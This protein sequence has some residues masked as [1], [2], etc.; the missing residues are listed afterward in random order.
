[1]VFFAG[2]FL[3]NTLLMLEASAQIDSESLEKTWVSSPKT[4]EQ[5]ICLRNH[6]PIESPYVIRDV[7]RRQRLG[8]EGYLS[9]SSARLIN[10]SRKVSID[11]HCPG[12]SWTLNRTQIE[13]PSADFHSYQWA[14]A[15]SGESIRVERDD[16]RDEWVPADARARIGFPS[17]P[18]ERGTPV[19]VAILDSG[20]AADHQEFQG[21]VERGAAFAYRDSDGHGTHV[22]GIIAAARDGR[23]ID[24]VYP[25]SRLMP[26]AV[27]E[28]NAGEGALFSML[29]RIAEGIVISVDQGA[30]IIN[31][32]LGWPDSVN[33]EVLRQ[34]VLYAEN[35]GVIIVAAAGN[36]ST[37]AS[38]YPCR[39][40]GVICVA[41]M[42]PDGGFAAFSNFGHGVDLVA[43]GYR[44]LSTIPLRNAPISF[45][46]GRGYD[47][48]SG[49]SM[50]APHVTGIL[51]KALDAGILPNELRA[52]IAAL[53]GPLW[54]EAQEGGFALAGEPIRSVQWGALLEASMDYQQ[55]LAKVRGNHIL[56]SLRTKEE[57]DVVLS[58]CQLKQSLGG[59]EVEWA[60]KN[61]S[62]TGIHIPDVL[63]QLEGQL[64]TEQGAVID[65]ALV[66]GEWGVRL[67]FSLGDEQVWPV[68]AERT[69]KVLV[70]APCAALRA[71]SRWVI[72]WGFSSKIN[73]FSSI[74]EFR[75][76]REW[77]TETSELLETQV[78]IE[79]CSVSCKI[80]W[81]VPVDRNHESIRS[82]RGLDEVNAR[83][84]AY[85]RIDNSRKR[86][87]LAWVNLADRV[88]NKHRVF[89]TGLEIS[90]DIQSSQIL[91]AWILPR[92]NQRPEVALLMKDSGQNQNSGFR[93]GFYEL[94]GSRSRMDDWMIAQSTLIVHPQMFWWRPSEF[95]SCRPAWVIPGPVPV[96]DQPSYDPWNPEPAQD[97]RG[98]LYTRV[99]DQWRALPLDRDQQILSAVPPTLRCGVG[100]IR[101]LQSKGSDYRISIQEFDVTLQETNTRN[102]WE[103]GNFRLAQQTHFRNLIGL[104]TIYGPG[105]AGFTGPTNDQTLRV[106]VRN[107]D[108]QW[109][110]RTLPQARFSDSWQQAIGV[111]P[112]KQGT[113]VQSLYDLAWVG[114]PLDTSIESHSSTISPQHRL[115]LERF[116]FLP[117]ALF[118]RSFFPLLDASGQM[119][120][121]RLSEVASREALDCVVWDAL[122]QRLR[123]PTE[124]RWV[125]PVEGDRLSV[126]A[127]T[128]RG[129]I[130]IVSSTQLFIIPLE[131]D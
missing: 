34:A 80:L 18:K 1:M 43:P 47:Y 82:I 83:W 38:V 36:D 27:T 9:L 22:A 73:G 71:N 4:A 60:L 117:G 107:G 7:N 40:P 105:V 37:R 31:M 101:V 69:V 106:S 19:R 46:Q 29:A 16:L 131:F 95:S 90:D 86:A 24:G 67:P 30:Q 49:T 97:L 64:R 124:S 50:A 84:R 23:G 48:K 115:S 85:L 91:D 128:D 33:N 51:A 8:G 45:S 56:L 89:H 103:R 100:P 121:C 127:G 77:G 10:S 57:P 88:S 20:L 94:D 63:R 75:T 28:Q 87:R 25:Y 53:A 44:I 79:N 108:G 52:F 54:T 111:W 116:S 15:N 59:V 58:G 65:G 6:A 102:Y 122:E 14:L 110:D 120:M 32:S 104:A 26:I 68:G 41:A 62:S 3:I 61:I 42:N 125:V 92:R 129:E 118:F 11:A 126:I 78:A 93:F 66:R 5:A 96:A 130:A 70:S 74:L 98:R 113:Y 17:W 12:L 112:E 123:R 13:L 21:R 72:D 39:F 2:Y 109:W 99:L 81:D 76:H 114:L 119:G 55:A 35:K